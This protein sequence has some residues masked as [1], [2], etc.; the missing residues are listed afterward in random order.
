MRSLACL[1]C[2]MKTPVS[3]CQ[4]RVDLG[5]PCNPIFGV[6]MWS[7]VDQM[8]LQLPTVAGAGN[9]TRALG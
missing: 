7:L 2:K 8:P 9:A 5:W 4:T 1:L 6:V 3:I